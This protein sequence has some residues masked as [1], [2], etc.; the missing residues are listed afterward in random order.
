LYEL[1]NLFINVRRARDR[2]QKGILASNLIAEIQ[3]RPKSSHKTTARLTAFTDENPVG[4]AEYRYV[5]KQGKAR[6]DQ[7]LEKLFNELLPQ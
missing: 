3:Q 4:P 2:L 1:D 6:F 7:L 5:A